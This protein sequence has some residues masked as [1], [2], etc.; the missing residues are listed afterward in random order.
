MNVVT[1][2][3]RFILVWHCIWWLGVNP[4][5]SCKCVCVCTEG[6]NN[7][8]CC[9]CCKCLVSSTSTWLW[10]QMS[11]L[12]ISRRVFDV[13]SWSIC[14][15]YTHRTWLQFPC[16]EGD[17]WVCPLSPIQHLVL[18]NESGHQTPYVG[19]LGVD[20]HVRWSIIRSIRVWCIPHQVRTM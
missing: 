3:N 13:P 15:F 14:A 18:C 9:N 5:M 1:S 7:P 19:V 16:R 10:F 11:L 2:E 12:V 4:H 20:W 6:M 8:S 17:Y